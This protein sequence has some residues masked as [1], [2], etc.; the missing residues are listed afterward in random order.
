MNK[1]EAILEEAKELKEEYEK[2]HPP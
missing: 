1:I 2:E